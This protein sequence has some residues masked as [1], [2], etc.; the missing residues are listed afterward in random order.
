MV[1]GECT[2]EIKTL[3]PKYTY[4]LTFQ[5]GQVTSAYVVNKYLEDFG[6]NPNCEVSGVKHH[7][8]QQ[9]SVD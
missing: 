6:K 2:F 8:M 5:N 1:T 9:I 3:N 4:P 7:V